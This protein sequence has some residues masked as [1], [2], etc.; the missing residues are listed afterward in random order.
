[1]ATNTANTDTATITDLI[2]ELTK[3]AEEE[4]GSLPLTLQE[5]LDKYDHT[6]TSLRDYFAGQALTGYA[7]SRP[8]WNHDITAKMAYQ[9]ADTMLKARDA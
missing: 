2:K 4:W 9:L 8:H 7:T 1:M 6:G 3:W 5:I